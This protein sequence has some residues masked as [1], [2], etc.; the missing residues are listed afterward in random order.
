MISPALINLAIEVGAPI[1]RKVLEGRIGKANA[2]FGS[3]VVAAIAERTG[4][5]VDTLPFLAEE[6]P[7]V[8]REAIRNVEASAPEM[9]EVYERGVERQFELLQAERADPVWMRAWRPMGMYVIGFLWLYA[10]VL[11]HVA[12]AVWK[13]ALPPP[14]LGI[15]FQLTA[16]YAGL[17][18]GGHTVKDIASKRWGRP[19]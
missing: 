3:D 7:D 10:I 1:V 11:L 15:L 16:V 4:V 9:L 14:D 18:M 6:D 17:Y 2:Q 13:I 12:N 8:V 19:R 5:S